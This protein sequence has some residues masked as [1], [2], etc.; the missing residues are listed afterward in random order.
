MVNLRPLLTGQGTYGP[1]RGGPFKGPMHLWDH[2]A[3]PPAQNTVIV[4]KDGTVL[5]GNNFDITTTSAPE[6]HRI[7]QGGYQHRCDQEDDPLSWQ[8]LKDAGYVCWLPELDLYDENDQYTDV[9]PR[10]EGTA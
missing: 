10:P 4:Y 3:G 2:V 7:F 1:L 6:V 8:A 5:E 9:Y